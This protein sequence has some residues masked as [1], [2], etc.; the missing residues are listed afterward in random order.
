MG[1]I[2]PVGEAGLAGEKVNNL[3]DPRPDAFAAHKTTQMTESCP[4]L[5]PGGPRGDG[6]SW[7]TWRKGN[8]GETQ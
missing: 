8:D 1:F 3:F 4:H 7:T 5:H 2:G 6:P